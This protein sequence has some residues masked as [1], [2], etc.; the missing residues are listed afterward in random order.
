LF[1]TGSRT[2]ARGEG[3]GRAANHRLSAVAA[4]GCAGSRRHVRTEYWPPPH[5]A[6]GLLPAGG[7]DALAVL[8]KAI[9]CRCQL[10]QDCLFFG[11]NICDTSRCPAAHARM[12]ERGGGSAPCGISCHSSMRR[13]SSQ[14]F[15][16]ARS[17]K[18]GIALRD[19]HANPFR[20]TAAK[21]A[22]VNPERS[23]QPNLSS[24]PQQDCRTRA[25]RH[26]GW[27]SLK[28]GH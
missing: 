25:R 27:P 24:N 15:S 5:H 9:K 4:C 17:G 21:A 2:M 10:H 23:S 1:A 26:N 18:P 16:A 22:A 7:R 14:A 19:V 8:D 6:K 12:R 28:T 3:Q 13:C 20:V 11:P